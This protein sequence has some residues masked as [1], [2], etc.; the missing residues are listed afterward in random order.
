M[1]NSS[2][3][4]NRALFLLLCP[5]LPYSLTVLAACSA[6]AGLSDLVTYLYFPNLPI[7]LEE[8]HQYLR[9]FKDYLV[10]FL[11]NNLRRNFVVV[12]NV[13]C[14]IAII[15]QLFLLLFS[16]LNYNKG[17]DWSMRVVDT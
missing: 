11:F 15:R 4:Y 5:S 16:K 12:K 7:S 1:L 3:T 2:I 8:K 6:S 10:D 13:V 9:I 14:F 17:F